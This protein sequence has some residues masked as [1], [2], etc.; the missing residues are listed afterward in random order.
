MDNQ[1]I[2]NVG[3][4]S[5]GTDVVN[6]NYV[7][8]VA[9]GRDWKE[10]V[11]AAATGDVDLAAPGGTFDGVA[12]DPDDRVLLLNQADASENG[13]Y[14]WSGAAAALVRAADADSDADVSAGLTVS[15]TEGTVL[16]NK[17]YVLYGD[18]SAGLGTA[19]LTFTVMAG[20]PAAVDYG[21][22][23]GLTETGGNT[24]SVVA[25]TGILVDGTGVKIDPSV[26]VRK[27]AANVGDGASTSITLPHNLGSRDV[28]VE[29][30]RNSGSYDT[31]FCEVTRPDINNVTLTFGTAP[32][33]AAFRAVVHV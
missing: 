14:V 23:N 27:Y 16:G 31:V 17:T 30:Y 10:S 6:K 21:A 24:F 32:A 11:R 9:A 29:V 4:P 2:I 12:L 8:N 19:D 18:L 22:G 15:V 7:D 3:S 20:G 5:G 13:I 26:V 28:T 33:A 1:R 25:S